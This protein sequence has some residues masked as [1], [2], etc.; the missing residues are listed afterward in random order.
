MKFSIFFVSFLSFVVFVSGGPTDPEPRPDQWW[1]DR[2]VSY[3]ENSA[4]NG[5]NI[6]LLFYGDSITEGWGGAGRQIFDQAYTPLGAANYG[7]GG[8]RTEHVLW[9]IING[10][11]ENINPKL[12]VLK[13]GT[14]R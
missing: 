9:R 1:I 14:K 8:D 3:V 6:N 12:I 2:H 5:G 10:E 11:V 4:T 13:I 7:I